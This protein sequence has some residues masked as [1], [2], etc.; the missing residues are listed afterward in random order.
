MNP[1]VYAYRKHKNLKLAASELGIAWQTLYVRLKQVNE[2]VT[3]DKLRYGNDRDKLAAFAESE[4]LR[5]VPSAVNA[6]DFRF[7][8]KY[9]FNVGD[10]KVDVKAS[11]PRQ[12]YKRYSAESWSFS[13][14]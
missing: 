8:A 4:F 5:L 7:Q 13:F 1:E 12:L 14:K 10:Y 3:G 9:D 6:N 2:P 11:K